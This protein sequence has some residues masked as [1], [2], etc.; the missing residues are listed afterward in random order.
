MCR[1]HFAIIKTFFKHFLGDFG[2]ILVFEYKIYH[3]TSFSLIMISFDFNTKTDI[4]V[5]SMWPGKY[6][7]WRL[8]FCT[9]TPKHIKGKISSEYRKNV[10]DLYYNWKLSM[11]L[12]TFLMNLFRVLKVPVLIHKLIPNFFK[13]LW[14]VWHQKLSYI[15]MRWF[16]KIISSKL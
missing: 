7:A 11:I 12:W 1:G 10:L 16:K 2:G 8:I 5:I 4:K 3:F 9:V 14:R 6:Q 13:A 15:N